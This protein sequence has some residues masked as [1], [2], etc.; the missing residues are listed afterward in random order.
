MEERKYV[1]Q[2][3]GGQIMDVQTR[4]LTDKG[5]PVHAERGN[6]PIAGGSEEGGGNWTAAQGQT[7]RE[8]LNP[9][10]LAAARVYPEVPC[11]CTR[12]NH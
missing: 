12:P 10:V 6:T 7:E 5:R 8:I 1:N 9:I 3:V 11:N 4:G 2:D